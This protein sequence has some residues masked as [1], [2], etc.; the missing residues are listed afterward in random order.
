MGGRF[1][2]RASRGLCVPEG[3]LVSAGLYGLM[4]IVD[5]QQAAV[6]TA[7]DGLIAERAAWQRERERLAREIAA[8]DLGTRAAVRSAGQESF[9]GVAVQGVEAVQ[10]AGQA[11]R[12]MHGVVLWA[13]WRLLGCL[14][15]V[16]AGLM[17]LV[18]VADTGILRW[19]T[20]AI[21]AAQARKAALQ[22]EVVEM[23]ANRDDWAKA[24]LLTKLEKCG[25][26][27]TP[28]VRVEEG[29]GA[30]GNQSDYRVILGY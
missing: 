17:P 16:L 7:L 19:N 11:E 6:R 29:A 27:A 20:S 13:S 9:S 22:A 14:L 2:D 26:K 15:V 12:T 10:A 23:Q 25:P 30:F 8:L 1:S 4:A 28:C 24:G 18:W 3:Q 21:G 5:R